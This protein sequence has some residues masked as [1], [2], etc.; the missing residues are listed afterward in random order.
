VSDPPH[1]SLDEALRAAGLEPTPFGSRAYRWETRT[2]RQSFST[3]VASLTHGGWYLAM[4]VR[5]WF[6]EGLAGAILRFVDGAEERLDL[7]EVSQILTGFHH[8]PF[9][10]DAVMLLSPRAHKQFLP[11]SEQLHARTLEAFPIFR[12]EFTGDE[13]ADVIELIRHRFVSTVDWRREASP[14]V[15]LRFFNA[16]TGVRSTG[17][18]MGLASLGSL[19]FELRTLTDASGSFIEIRNFLGEECRVTAAGDTILVSLPDPAPRVAL[20]R[21]ESQPWVR[22]FLIR[23][24][25]TATDPAR[26]AGTGSP[27]RSGSSFGLFLTDYARERTIP[28]QHPLEAPSE[29]VL[30]E[31]DRLSDTRGCFLGVIRG[32]GLTLQ[33]HWNEDSTLLADVPAPDRA[34]SLA[35]LATHAECRRLLESFLAGAGLDSMPDLVFSSWR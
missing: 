20:T 34:G 35:K 2:P 25:G 30:E 28:S 26:Q 32:D 31:F 29:R 23:G 18:R 21:A 24:L 5:D 12:C 3:V 8:E 9:G 33:F 1:P 7:G 27:D 10:F 13:P 4:V 6:D 17:A 22:G 11:R 16:R 15:H 14:Q 19:E